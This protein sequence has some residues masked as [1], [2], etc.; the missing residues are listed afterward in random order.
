[1]GAIAG[2]TVGGFILGVL[3]TLLFLILSSHRTKKKSPIY[4]TDQEGGGD[5]SALKLN[6]P[7]PTLGNFPKDMVVSPPPPSTENVT[8]TR[9]RSGRFPSLRSSISSRAR[10][11]FRSTSGGST[12]P[13]FDL[14]PS[15]YQQSDS[16]SSPQ[17]SSATLGGST[18]FLGGSGNDLSRR[19]M[20]K[21]EGSSAGPSTTTSSTSLAI[22]GERRDGAGGAEE[23]VPGEEAG[24]EVL[25]ETGKKGLCGVPGCDVDH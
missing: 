15:A 19:L 14:P 6:L 4:D 23:A 1:M 25:K 2:G 5:S 10:Q 8:T 11:A 7:S 12:L 18:Y 22:V 13:I 20:R 17:T 16:F 3:S 9:S 21:G 24:Q